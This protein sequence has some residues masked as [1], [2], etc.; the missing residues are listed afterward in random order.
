[1]AII[2][3]L[4]GSWFS[5]NS[6]NRSECLPVNQRKPVHGKSVNPGQ[7]HTSMLYRYPETPKPRN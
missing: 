3:V 6:V 5:E 7:C 1:M 2:L 4:L